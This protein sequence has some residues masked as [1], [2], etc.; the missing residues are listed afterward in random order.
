MLAGRLLEVQSGLARG[1]NG[2]VGLA[3]GCQKL[4]ALAGFERAR[5]R[6]SMGLFQYRLRRPATVARGCLEA[7]S[8]LIRSL[9]WLTT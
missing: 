3:E 9:S 5:G 1:L 8:G 7:Q 6:G 2:L 4:R